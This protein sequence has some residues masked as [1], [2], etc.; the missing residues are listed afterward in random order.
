[1]PTRILIGAAPADKAYAVFSLINMIIYF[2]W[3][4]ILIVH[5]RAVALSPQEAA[6]S[7][8]EFSQY[9]VGSQSETYNPA[10]GPVGGN[11]GFTGDQEE[12]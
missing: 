11:D 4:L 12:L 9:G 2:V 8:Q 5:R 7:S 3:T 10:I 1:M 6:A